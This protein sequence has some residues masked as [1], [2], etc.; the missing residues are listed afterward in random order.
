MTDT[1]RTSADWVELVAA[2]ADDKKAQNIVIMDMRTVFPVTDYF[3]IAGANST[4][5][6]RAIAD[7]IE[8]KMEE[9]GQKVLHKEGYREG[10]WILLDYGIVVA[11]IFVNDER[12]FYN[13]E[14]LWSGA[15]IR[16]FQA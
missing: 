7:G 11:H 1:E 13:L 5:Q 8:E 15:P 3:L 2:A 4:T 6:V 14:H 10:H 16:E 9:A 12:R